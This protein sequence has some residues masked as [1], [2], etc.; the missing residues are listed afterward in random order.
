MYRWK[1][2][3]LV[4]SWIRICKWFKLEFISVSFAKLE[5]SRKFGAKKCTELQEK[6][7]TKHFF[8][9][10]K[11]KPAS[12]SHNHTKFV[13]NWDSFWNNSKSLMIYST[14]L[15]RKYKQ[16][17]I[18]M[19]ANDLISNNNN[20]CGDNSGSSSSTRKTICTCM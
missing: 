3:S 2:V 13:S 7:H 14:R 16:F 5:N 11:Q 10:S 20:I 19:I 4:F 12:D 17:A 18:S 15:M 9:K 1:I 8:N 6:K